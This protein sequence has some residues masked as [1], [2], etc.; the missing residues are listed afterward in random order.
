MTPTLAEYA[1]ASRTLT[2]RSSRVSVCRS[3]SSAAVAGPFPSNGDAAI[4]PSA[5][6]VTGKGPVD[7][8]EEGLAEASW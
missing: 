5:P 4:D 6:T 7:V 8:L 1:I 2:L 3:A